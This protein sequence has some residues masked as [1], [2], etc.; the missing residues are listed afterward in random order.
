M[1]NM[2]DFYIFFLFYRKWSKDTH[3]YFHKLWKN[4]Y[5]AEAGVT[6]IPAIRITTDDQPYD[7][8]WKDVVYGCV[9]MSKT[10]LER[11][12]SVHKRNYK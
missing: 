11:L 2:I 10:V 4:G 6:L 1:R 5:A 3:D 12:S 8:P 9:D 7:V